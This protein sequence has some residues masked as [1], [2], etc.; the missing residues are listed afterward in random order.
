MPTTISLRAQMTEAARRRNAERSELQRLQTENQ[1]LARTVR[2]QERI[3]LIQKQRLSVPESESDRKTH[4]WTASGTLH[5]QA[6]EYREQARSLFQQP[7]RNGWQRVAA[8]I[9]I[10]KTAIERAG[11]FPKPGR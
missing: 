1:R 2:E 7:E 6:R 9:G 3:I 8:S 11:E 4:L 10:G 5:S